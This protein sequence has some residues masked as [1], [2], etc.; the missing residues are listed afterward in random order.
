VARR[1][2]AIDAPSSGDFD[3][4]FSGSAGIVVAG[5]GLAAGAGY[6]RADLFGSP[7]DAHVDGMVSVRGYQAY[8]LAL[9]LLGD[10]RSTLEL[11]AA[12]TKVASL[13]NDTA[14]KREGWAIYADARYRDY[15]RHTLYGIGASSR[16]GDRSD[17]TLKGTSLDLVWQQQF[18][19]DIG[20]SLRAGLL[21]LEIGPGRNPAIEDVRTRF[22][23]ERLPGGSAVPR[24]ATW[25]AGFVYDTRSVPGAPD[26]GTFV[27]I[28]VRHF[29][30]SAAERLDFTR[31]TIDLRGY[32]SP[33]G[34]R[35]VLA[36][37]ALVATDL[38]EAGGAV[39]FSLQQSLGGSE[40]LRGF[41]SY[42]FQDDAFVHGT[43]EYR[44]RVHR[45]VEVAPVVDAGV[46]GS[47]L[48]RLAVH[49]MRVTPGVGARL[50]SNR[51]TLVRLDWARSAEGHRVVFATGP[52][53]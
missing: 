28:T 5:S 20:V 16:R 24:Y 41:P 51:R 30:Q 9:G 12:E 22:G 47:A 11:D 17:Y 6:R 31:A 39:P 49:T 52:L 8:R 29:A 43:L 4:G 33:L 46:V 18:A 10:W 40:T 25:G 38:T 19:P 48:S 13:F 32:A 2:R 34:D 21:D 27:G 36:G 53:F 1:W 44:W 14:S 50:R 42:R 35:G 7:I 37:R 45:Y 23:F 15:P 3:E 26:D